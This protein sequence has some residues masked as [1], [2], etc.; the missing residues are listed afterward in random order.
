[1]RRRRVVITGVGVVA[2]NGIGKDSFWRSLIAGHSA[3]DYI[4]AF[5][6]SAYPSKIAAEVRGFRPQDFMR[7]QTFKTMGRFSQFAVASARLA[8]EDAELTITPAL[9]NE[10]YICYG[11]SG[12]ADVFETAARASTEHGSSRVSPWAAL[13]YPPHASSSY[14]SIEFGI[15]GPA[16]SLSS[17]C[18]TGLDAV[19]TAAALIAEGRTRVSITGSCEAPISPVAFGTFCALGSLST[20]SCPPQHASRPYDRLRDGLVISE[21]GAT[22]VLEDLEFAESRGAHIYGEIRGG[23]AG[24]EALGMRKGDLSGCV[25][26]NVISRALANAGLDPDEIDHIN[27]HGSSLPDFDLCDTNGFKLALGDHAYRIPITSIKSMIGQPFSAAG[28]LQTI[29]ACLA[30][31]HQLV[32]PTINQ[33]VLDPDCDLDYVPNRARFVRLRNVLI[34]GHSFGGSVSALVLSAPMA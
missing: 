34:N 26:G 24:S 16:V 13:E 33:D 19:R 6:A 22:L 32:P 25:L 27:A 14:L 8:L 12:G 15:R 28:G 1:M 7:R 4:T 18:C 2:P 23:A 29:A 11:A 31:Q 3:V 9:S 5:D 10:I 17:N 20:R 21:G 30:I